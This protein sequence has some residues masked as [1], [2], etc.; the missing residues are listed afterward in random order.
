MNYLNSERHHEDLFA[1]LS[2][3]FT[4]GVLQ[5]LLALT[6]YSAACLALP[7]ELETNY[8]VLILSGTLIVYSAHTWIKSRSNVVKWNF[9]VMFYLVF[10]SV[11]AVF[12]SFNLLSEWKYIRHLAIP[13]LIVILYLIPLSRTIRS[14]LIP[15]WVKPVSL[16]IAWT[17]IC[18]GP[19]K[20]I[21]I[22]TSYYLISVFFLILSNAIVF[23]VKDIEQDKRANI[24]TYAI[25]YGWEASRKAA[26][27]SLI[28]SIIAII[29]FY[30]TLGFKAFIAGLVP[31]LYIFPLQQIKTDSPKNHY[32][33]YLDGALFLFPV[34]ICLMYILERM[35]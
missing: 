20:Q 16:A 31:G 33:W 21:D 11:A 24:S 34:A 17:W 30:K 15:G 5:S 35:Y 9:S 1:G 27:I 6:F 14:E 8:C 4:Y 2:K 12:M 28:I 13:A 25:Q 19:I 18:T 23:D 3:F 29:L 26:H 10:L 7:M 32:Y 22:R